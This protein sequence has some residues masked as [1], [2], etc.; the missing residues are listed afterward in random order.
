[1]TMTVEP[2][3]LDWHNT[4]RRTFSILPDESFQTALITA[5]RIIY[6]EREHKIILKNSRSIKTFKISINFLD[7]DMV[8]SNHTTTL[9]KR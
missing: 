9:P 5:A 4:Q 6:N 3:T 7:S 8:I 2:H 1:M